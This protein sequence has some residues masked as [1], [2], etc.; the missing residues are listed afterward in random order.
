MKS[1][2]LTQSIARIKIFDGGFPIHLIEVYLKEVSA[3]GLE[4]VFKLY[5]FLILFIIL[6]MLLYHIMALHYASKLTKYMLKPG[7]MILIIALAIYGSGLETTFAK[8]IVVALFFSLIGDVFLMLDDRWFVHGLI[9]FFIA[10]I[11]YL[12]AFWNSFALDVTSKTS[13]NVAVLLIIFS[14]WFFLFLIRFVIAEG[15]IRLAIAV[16][17]YILV[18]SLMMWSASLTDSGILVVASLLFVI[19]DAVLAYDK[20]RQPFRVAEHIVM[21]TYF[22]AQL[23]FAISI[24]LTY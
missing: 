11:F 10:H 18:I 9:S 7:T 2:Q 21:V 5:L 4:R 15:G 6:S 1:L 22:T 12:I 17:A 3:K 13:I 14:I 23:L 20:F 16:A 24:G 19:S 8:W